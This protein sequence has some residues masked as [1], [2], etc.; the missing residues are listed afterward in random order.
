MESHQN[1]NV[2]TKKPKRNQSYIILYCLPF[3]FNLQ[4]WHSISQFLQ[5]SHRDAVLNRSEIVPMYIGL[6]LAAVPQYLV[7]IINFKNLNK[8][9][10]FLQLYLCLQNYFKY[11]SNCL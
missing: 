7:Q 3:A 11:M 6:L 10:V 1:N 4:N 5:V 9:K 8:M 2:V